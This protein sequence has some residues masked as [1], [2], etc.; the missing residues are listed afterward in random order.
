MSQIHCVLN[1][2]FG[3][4]CSGAATC[5]RRPFR[6]LD[7]VLSRLCLE[8]DQLRPYAIGDEDIRFGREECIWLHRE[9]ARLSVS[10]TYT[11]FVAQ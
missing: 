10:L 9:L 8:V 3:R 1:R 11:E 6:L 5:G 7:R 2:R 4:D